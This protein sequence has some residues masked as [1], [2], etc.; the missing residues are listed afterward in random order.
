MNTHSGT[1]QLPSLADLIAEKCWLD[2]FRMNMC[3]GGG[4]LR[5]PPAAGTAAVA[6]NA[7]SGMVLLAAGMR[8]GFGLDAA[9]PLQQ[10]ARLRRERCWSLGE[11]ERRARLQASLVRLWAR[12]VTQT[13]LFSCRGVFVD[14]VT[15]CLMSY[16]AI[17]RNFCPPTGRFAE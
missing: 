2:D 5:G 13:C 7:A 11:L 3:R 17:G 15:S 8:P 10:R 6:T 16:K 14:R 12:A 4:G 9:G 1:A